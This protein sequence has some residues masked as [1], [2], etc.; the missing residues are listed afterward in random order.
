MT[1]PLLLADG[2]WT[3]VVS[4]GRTS[5]VRTCTRYCDYACLFVLRAELP[6]GWRNRGIIHPDALLAESHDVATT[7]DLPGKGAP[8]RTKLVAI[9]PM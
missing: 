3:A 6:H 5:I 2:G 7:S 1:L 8:A 4:D 9:I